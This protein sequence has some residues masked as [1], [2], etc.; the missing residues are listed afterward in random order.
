MKNLF[1]HLF[2]ERLAFQRRYFILQHWKSS[3]SD[4]RPKAYSNRLYTLLITF[5]GSLLL[6]AACSP[7]PQA[8]HEQFI[9]FGTLVEVKIWG[10][11]ADQGQ[12]ATAALASDFERLHKAWHAWQPGSLGRINQLLPTGGKFSVSPSHLDLIEQSQR[13]SKQSGGRFN[14]AIGQLIKLWGFASDDP[15]RG[16]PPA[17]FEIEALLRKKPS[18]DNI[19]VDGIE[20]QSNNEAVRL[21]FGGFAKGV[22]VDKAVEHLQDLGIH[23]A[24]VNAGGDLRAIGKHGDRPWRI[25]IRDPRGPGMLAS[26]DVEG[27]ESV[28]TSGDYERFFEYNGIRF[29]HIIDPHSG[30][31]ARG[32]TSVTVFHNKAADADAAATALFVAGP[33]DWYEVARAM[34]VKGVMLVDTRGTIY[35]T[36]NLKDRIYFDT[37]TPPTIIYSEPL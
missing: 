12:Q 1:S 36:P 26:V 8:Y 22:A 17:A 29:H 30:Y 5:I 14:P 20:I 21:D 33:E 6:L 27:D 24:I 9:A 18:M 37:E 10:V 2:S 13:L 3:D 34:G 25:G 31:P 16:P 19:T 7:K 4:S 15:P 35:M 32:T 23:H 11:E 28:F